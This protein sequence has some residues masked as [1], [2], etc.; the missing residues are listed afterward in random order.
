MHSV[1]RLRPGVLP[2]AGQGLDR[3]APLSAEP[4]QHIPDYRPVEIR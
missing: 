2:F 4:V 3:P 1:P